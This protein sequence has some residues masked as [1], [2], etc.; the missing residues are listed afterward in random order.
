MTIYYPLLSYYPSQNGGPANTLY[1]LHNELEKHNIKCI[2][3]S[4]DLGIPVD[5]IIEKNT[6]GKN[7]EV[8]FVK[9][10]ILN[11][12]NKKQFAKIKSSNIIHFSSIFFP[13]TLPILFYSLIKKKK[14]IVSPRGEL[15]PPALKI[16]SH[17]KK[18]WLLFFKLFQNKINFH[19]TNEEEKKII[20]TIFSKAKRIDKI[21]NLISLPE[22][23]DLPIENQILFLGRINPIKNIDILI[24]SFAAIFHNSTHKGLKLIIAGSAKL[25]YELKYKLNLDKLISELDLTDQIVFNGEIMGSEKERIISSSLVLVLPSKSENFGNVVLEAL[26]QGT[27]IIASIHT[28]WQQLEANNAGYCVE[29]S[30]LEL[31]KA[32]E[33]IL[34]MKESTY[35]SMRNSSYSYC[36]NEF[37]ILTKIGLWLEY[38]KNI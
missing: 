5:L 27:P 21:P 34:N 32:L 31:K 25:P 6:W 30:Q 29:P 8:E 26:S 7:N 20:Q 38:Y 12:L 1:W 18:V 37:D 13:P 28:P 10:G 15:Y 36:K 9:Q 2:V 14:I 19:A 17:R 3:T 24:K 35:S 11:F 23:L 16:K 33:N 22:K 4:T